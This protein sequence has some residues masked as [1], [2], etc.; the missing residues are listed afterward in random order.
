MKNIL[1]AL[2]GTFHKGGTE[3]VVLSYYNNIDH[4]KY[5]IDFLV[6]GHEEDCRDNDIH[7]YLLSCGSRLYY[8]TPRGE[9]FIK[10]Q[11]EMAKVLREN[12]YEIVHSHM[13][14]AGYFF[15]KEAKK[16]GVPV[17][18]SHS[19]NTASQN[20][21]SN[22]IK[23]TV[24]KTIHNRSIKKLSEIADVKIACSTEAGNWLFNGTKFAVL[25]N[26][27]DIEKY[28]FDLS[29]REEIRKHLGIKDEITIGH[30]GRF[31]VQKNHELL[32]KIFAEYLN[33]H[34]NSKLVLVGTGELFEVVR[35]KCTSLGIEKN[36]VF[37]GTR[38]DVNEL[39]QAFDIFLLPSLYE[40]LPVVGIE[41]QASGLPCVISSSVSPEVKLS[42]NVK[43]VPLDAPI[44][45]WCDTIDALYN[46]KT[47][48]TKGSDIVRNAGYDIKQVV[49]QLMKIYEDS[50]YEKGIKI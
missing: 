43:L 27:I 19:H 15:L 24:Y 21:Q 4:T 35:Q 22:I 17:C 25:N 9:N 5:H 14:A 38:N 3:A 40:G 11:R 18:V 30:V 45:C 29:K 37:L 1:Y 49:N 50:L 48:R 12:K 46:K 23:R 28:T 32:I 42:E 39:M 16:A 44:S 47:D 10:N 20:I 31:A 7:K 36:I 2:N 33:N 34:K 8:V 13:D 6:H 41:A 26:A